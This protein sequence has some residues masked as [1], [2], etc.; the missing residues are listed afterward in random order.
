MNGK[1]DFAR[2]LVRF[3]GTRRALS[4][5]ALVGGIAVPATIKV[6]DQR[7]VEIVANSACAM[8]DDEGCLPQANKYCGLRV[9]K[10][11]LN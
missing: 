9:N 4:L 11:K 3:S 7:G 8:V 10:Y 1:L 6:S 2:S 5:A